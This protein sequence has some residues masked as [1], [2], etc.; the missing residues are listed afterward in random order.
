MHQDIDSDNEVDST[1][2]DTKPFLVRGAEEH[3][4]DYLDLL[5]S[6]EEEFHA[7]EDESD[8]SSTSQESTESESSALLAGDEVHSEVAVNLPLSLLGEQ[9]IG[10]SSMSSAKDPPFVEKRR[11]DLISQTLTDSQT[12]SRLP[13]DADDPH[14]TFP[15]AQNNPSWFHNNKPSKD[16]GGS[17]SGLPAVSTQRTPKPDVKVFSD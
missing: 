4:E 14:R 3:Q 16:G 8:D 11:N 2:D 17:G 7:I 6:S 5:A 10:I 13:R 1:V 15:P 12:K 9:K